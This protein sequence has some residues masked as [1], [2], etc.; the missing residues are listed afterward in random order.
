M[1]ETPTPQTSW[2][3]E[4]RPTQQDVPEA[5]E[6]PDHTFLGRFKES[7]LNHPDSRDCRPLFNVH[8]HPNENSTGTDQRAFT[9]PLSVLAGFP[10]LPLRDEVLRARTDFSATLQR[11]V[12]L[13]QV[14]LREGEDNSMPPY[15][16]LACACN[17]RGLTDG[18]N[19]N[20]AQQDV[21]RNLLIAADQ[22]YSFMVE[23]DNRK[24]RSVDT[25]L[26][27]GCKIKALLKI[28]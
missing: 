5:S 8:P 20:R 23:T 9:Y 10:E 24:S 12:F 17:G 19:G 21:A 13:R 1:A 22:L 26:S 18:S 27:V 14:P 7:L 3:G 6:L 11:H 16:L 4:R 15:L 28:T 25:I 2:P